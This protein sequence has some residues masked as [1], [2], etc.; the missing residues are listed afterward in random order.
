[1]KRN[2]IAVTG[3]I[4]SGKSTVISVLSQMGFV[5]FN[6]DDIARAIADDPQ[7]ISDVRALLGE[8]SIQNG[9]LDRKYIRQTVFADARL[10][11]RYGEIFY[12]RVKNKLTRLCADTQCNTV[13]VEIAV[14]NAFDFDWSEVWQ[15]VCP[16]EKQAVRVQIR[17]NVCKNDVQNIISAQR[18]NV[19]CTRVI[20]NDGTIAQLRK[21]VS[22]AVELAQLTV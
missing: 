11:Q 15:V 14:L 17:D 20:H 13:F 8:R 6:C 10:L 1:M 7:V 22:E 19:K 16:P 2:I 21:R 4:G 5:T 18:R 12:S 3:L 9:A